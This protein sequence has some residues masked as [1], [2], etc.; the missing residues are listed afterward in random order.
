MNWLIAR[1]GESSTW[2][3]FI[4]LLTFAG[5]TLKPEQSEAII[6]AGIALA[7]LLGVFLKEK[8][9]ALPPIELQGKSDSPAPD[10]TV[11]PPLSDADRAIVRNVRAKSTELRRGSV[12]TDRPSDIGWN[13]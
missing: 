8:S 10:S 3:G 7:G 6:A 13:G 1:L 5:L 9:V 4:W 11:A 12:P 2:R